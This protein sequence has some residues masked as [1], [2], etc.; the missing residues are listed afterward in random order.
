MQINALVQFYS[1][2]EDDLREKK[3]LWYTVKK[4]LKMHNMGIEHVLVRVLPYLAHSY[5]CSLE[6]MKQ[7]YFIKEDSRYFSNVL[8]HCLEDKYSGGGILALAYFKSILVE[9]RLVSDSIIIHL[10]CS[11]FAYIVLEFICIGLES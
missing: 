9:I 2:F 1:S 11:L 7:M 4:N 5:V 10:F 8:F 6:P 3:K